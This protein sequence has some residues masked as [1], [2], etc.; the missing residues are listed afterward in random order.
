MSTVM[1]IAILCALSVFVILGFCL[2]LCF[3]AQKLRRSFS[4]C[5]WR[6]SGEKGSELIDRV[7]V[8]E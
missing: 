6:K 8:I 5:P 2:L 3:V 4:V 1:N 7:A